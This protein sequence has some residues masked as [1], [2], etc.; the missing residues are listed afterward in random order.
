MRTMAAMGM[1]CTGGVSG[2]S[3]HFEEFARGRLCTFQENPHLW[4]PTLKV[5]PPDAIFTQFCR[6]LGCAYS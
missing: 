3:F 5:R 4:V 1:V 2:V 6:I